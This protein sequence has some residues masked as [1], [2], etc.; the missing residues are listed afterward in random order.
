[1][2]ANYR[3]GTAVCLSDTASV[4]QPSN[5]HSGHW[6]LFF[7]RDFQIS[8]AANAEQ[9]R[10]SFRLRHQV[11]CEELSFEPTNAD[12]EEQDS[13]DLRSAHYLLHHRQTA[14]L[15]G[16]M[17]MIFCQNDSEPLPVTGYF[18]N[19]F[20]NHQLQP[21]AFN[22]KSICELSRLALAGQFRRQQHLHNA[23]LS[24]LNP[25]QVSSN[26]SHYR[27]LA[28]GL[29]LAA[30]EHAA[31][32]GLAHAYAVIAPALARMLN[33]VGF[34]FQQ[35]SLP[36][37]L[38]GQRAAYYLNVNKSLET[39]CDDYKLLRL[40]LTAQLTQLGRSTSRE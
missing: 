39:L 33:R 11:Y 7:Q 22:P 37:E 36:I 18:Y 10:Q 35:I 38:N 25:L 3:A 4:N 23:A 20:T 19:R 8:R 17:R 1:M 5:P 26:N 30:L 34:Q 29:Y 24:Q 13:Y 14:S 21:T 2:H 15:A 40:V 32:E 16:T 27:Y 28:A 12:A 9:L 31:S 6:S